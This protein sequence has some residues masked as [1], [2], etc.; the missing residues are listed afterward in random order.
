MK[1]LVVDNTHLICTKDNEYYSP[2]IYSYGFYKRYL[3]VFDE[4]KIIGKTKHVDVVDEKAYL[5]I[6]GPRLEVAELPWYQGMSEMCRL[7]PKLFRLYR[8]V[9]DDCDCCILRIAQV[10]SFLFYMF[11]KKHLP[12]CVEVVNDPETFGARF[13]VVR[14]FSVY[15][16]KKMTRK[17]NGASYVT[18]RFLQSKYPCKAILG[19]N[20]GFASHYSSIE[21]DEDGIAKSPIR[22]S[23]GEFRIVHVS[24]AINTDDKGH[25]A[26]IKAFAVINKDISETRLMII[27]DG[28]KLSEYKKLASDLG[29]VDKVTFTGRVNDKNV[30]FDELRNSNL[31]IMPT[32]MEGLPRTIIE[33]MSVGLPCLSS[34]T[35]GVPELI[36]Q[37]YLFPPEDFNAFAQKTIRLIK[38]PDELY[39]M[40]IRNIEESKKYCKVVLDARRTEF[41]QNLRRTVND[42]RKG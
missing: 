7:F 23:G 6:S 4:V 24:N 21:L 2:S 12:F 16:T 19:F 11:T 18:E 25:T 39:E 27:G 37:K 34:P 29:V 3:N 36:E 10:E 32:K 8:H 40:S 28:S 13:D 14:N 1:V 42:K 38:S 41:Y 20:D 33:A 22:Y 26:L 5:K 35:A 30:L 9:A 17:A 15:M 31:M